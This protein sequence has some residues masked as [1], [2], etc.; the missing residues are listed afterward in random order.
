[1]STSLI[2]KFVTFTCSSRRCTFVNV[3]DVDHVADI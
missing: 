3:W 2:A 1:M